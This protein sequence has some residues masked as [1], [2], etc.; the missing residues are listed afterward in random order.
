MRGRTVF[1]IAHRFS[2]ILDCDRIALLEAGR[3]EAVGTHDQLLES[4]DLYRQLYDRQLLG[5]A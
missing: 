4:S 3:V 5:T 1:V 2:T